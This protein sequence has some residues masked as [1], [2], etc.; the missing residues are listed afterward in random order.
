MQYEIITYAETKCSYMQKLVLIHSNICIC[1]YQYACVNLFIERFVIFCC[2][3]WIETNI[4]SWLP[5]CC[6]TLNCMD[7][8]DLSALF[9]FVFFVVVFSFSFVP[10]SKKCQQSIAKWVRIVCTP[11][12]L[13]HRNRQKKN[14]L[15]H[16]FLLIGN[17]W[18][19]G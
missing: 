14:L 6:P 11:G 9:T 13:L 19:G 8:I 16:M 7:E 10:N 17:E 2:H 15:I 12:G 1:M 4:A 5:L 18:Y 3:N